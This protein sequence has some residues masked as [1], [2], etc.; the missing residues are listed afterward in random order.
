VLTIA[1][2]EFSPAACETALRKALADAGLGDA[3]VSIERVRELPRHPQT[4]K[5]KRFVPLVEK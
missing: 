3:E 1:H 2:G 4:N 5:L